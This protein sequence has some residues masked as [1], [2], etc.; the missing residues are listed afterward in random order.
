MFALINNTLRL[1]TQI[2]ISQMNLS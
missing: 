2:D 1:I